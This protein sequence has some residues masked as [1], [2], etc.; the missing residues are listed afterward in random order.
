VS[1]GPVVLAELRDGRLSVG[2]MDIFQARW[3]QRRLAA[4]DRVHPVA[5]VAVRNET[6]EPWEQVDSAFAA[7]LA[8]HVLRRVPA[9][10]RAAE[11]GGTLILIPRARV[12]EF[13]SDGRYV[14]VKYAF[15]GEDRGNRS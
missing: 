13:L 3:M 2:E 6:T 11:H 8:S 12:S 14:Q 15:H 1:V 10:V 5:P 4:A 7:V 9:T